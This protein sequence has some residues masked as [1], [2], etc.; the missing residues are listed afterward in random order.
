MNLLDIQD[1]FPYPPLNYKSNFLQINRIINPF[2]EVMNIEKV[3]VIGTGMMGPGIAAV[4]AL[5]GFDVTLISERPD[6]A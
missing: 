6:W 1:L 2:G 3:A 4:I 5:A